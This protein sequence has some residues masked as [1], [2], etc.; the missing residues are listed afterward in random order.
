MIVEVGIPSIKKW[1]VIK[2]T[3][4]VFP[5]ALFSVGCPTTKYISGVVVADQCTV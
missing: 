2:E 4:R 1:D 3:A 5:N